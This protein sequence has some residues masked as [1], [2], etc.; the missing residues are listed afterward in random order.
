MLAAVA[1]ALA[2]PAVFATT[3]QAERSPAWTHHLPHRHPVNESVVAVVQDASGGCL[4]TGRAF[5]SM[6]GSGSVVTARYNARGRRLWLRY[7][8]D[9]SAD[10]YDSGNEVALDR[11][12]NGYVL[13]QYARPA[14]GTNM[15]LLKYSP[16]GRLL[17]SRRF[18]SPGAVDDYPDA[19]VVTPGGTA[20]A[21]C[22]STGAGSAP[23]LNVV[24]FAASGR[25]VWVSPYAM[26]GTRG[27]IADLLPDGAGGLY[28]AGGLEVAGAG[29]DGFVA[30]YSTRTGRVTWSDLVA[31]TAGADDT[32][33]GLALHGQ[34]LYA[35]GWVTSAGTGPDGCVQKYLR[36]NGS[37]LAE[38][39]WD[40]GTSAENRFS[41][42][43]T[44]DHGRYWV[45]AG[46]VDG[47]SAQPVLFTL[48]LSNSLGQ[49][50]TRTLPTG[51]PVV[52]ADIAY[53]GSGRVAVA[54]MV[55]GA[56]AVTTA[57]AQYR[58][59]GV[60]RWWAIRN[61][62]P[63]LLA[64]EIDASDDGSVTAGGLDGDIID[65]RAV[66]IHFGR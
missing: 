66:V 58:Q 4:V 30:R 53:A 56:A 61:G 18:A 21:A 22:D 60:R 45:A 44:D 29:S 32:L 7:W 57:F 2:S 12:G 63:W 13:A 26:P 36:G 15:V 14:T 41:G 16:R 28:A 25:R 54:G 17:W 48:R 52:S 65:G 8:D 38:L 6:P 19:L 51:G 39:V 49:V 9:S 24:K 5:L 50:W 47:G 1:V 46:G 35:S 40:D 62:S 55:S 64:S 20:Y 43:V 11:A 23:R 37:R 33:K 3:A 31:G 34:W 27:W 10:S 59:T 42:I